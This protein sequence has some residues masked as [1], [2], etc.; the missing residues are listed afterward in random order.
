M[1]RLRT[2]RLGAFVLCA[3]AAAATVEAATIDHASVGCT[4]ADRF[5][6]LEAG[7][8]P[9]DT[10]GRARVLFKPE[11]GA[12]WYAVTMARAG[13]VYAA[14]LP[15]P[16]KTLG[17]FRYY[18]EVA[19]TSF[20]T[21]RTE[22]YRTEVVTGMG[23]CRQGMMMG[24]SVPAASV[25]LE[26]PAGAAAVP[27]GFSSTGVVA[28]K[29]AA[30]GVVAGTAAAAGGGIGATTIALV[31]AGVAAAGAGVAVATGAVGG[32]DGGDDGQS[33]PQEPEV[34]IA[35]VRG[36]VFGALTV[37]PANP[38]GPGLYGPPV[39]GALVASSLD[40]A[41]TR[42]DAGGNF[43]LVTQTRLR[44]SACTPFTLTITAAGYPTFSVVAS[45]A[46]GGSNPANP[47]LVFTLLPPQFPLPFV[48][49]C[50]AP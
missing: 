24:T 33:N 36:Q 29:V 27:S 46:G 47:P 17:S 6:R 2:A 35:Q 10:I 15:K 28:A 31:G 22:E 16:Q 1:P 7:L 34:P 12:H 19:D 42:T 38:T 50:N 21:S 9:I 26:A 25:M 13:D 11:A 23:G 8:A 39:S 4:M 14:T 48:G 20:A 40:S 18:L 30:A 5:P 45:W 41:T 32:G 43:L 37:N 49:T 3:S 44:N